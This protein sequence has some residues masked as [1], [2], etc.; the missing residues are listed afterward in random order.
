MRFSKF[1]NTKY[2]SAHD[3]V[4]QISKNVP[5]HVQI[6]TLK[7]TFPNGKVKGD[8]FYI[9][10]L[11]GEEGDSLRIDI[12]PRSNNFMR[13]QDFNGGVGVGGIVK[14]LMEARSLRLPE[15]QKMFGSYLNQPVPVKQN[16]AVNMPVVT[17]PK[18]N[19]TSEHTGEWIY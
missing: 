3:L 19:I 18:V 14:I 13:G 1:D 5:S 16:V 8:V 11:R 12:N 2:G 17:K 4:E 10:S 6:N 15:I 7:D 9:G